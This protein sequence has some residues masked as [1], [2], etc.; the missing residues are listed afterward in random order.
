MFSAAT[1]PTARA[2]DDDVAS[3]RKNVDKWEDRLHYDMD[4][5]G[6]DSKQVRHDRHEL[7]EA[8]ESCHRRFGDRYHDNDE[9]HDYDRDRNYNR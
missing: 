7:D 3:C 5:H 6:Q 8:R 4:R 9:H 2:D 1:A